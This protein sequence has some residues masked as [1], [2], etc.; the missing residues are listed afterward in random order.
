MT[1][2]HDLLIFE[3]SYR[4]LAARIHAIDPEIRISLMD[5]SGQISAAGRAIEP[6]HASA[7]IGWPN[8]DVFVS[9]R[10]SDYLRALLKSNTLRW[11]QS[12]AAGVDDPI[13]ARLAAKGL[14]LT[15]SDA[16]APAMADF[17]LGA[18]LEFH[19]EQAQRRQLQAARAWQ[20]VT[21]TELA[22]TSWL[23]VGYGHIGRE[24]ARRAHAFGAAIT[25]V[26]RD[27]QP[28]SFARSI[29]TLDHLP[30]CL[31]HADVVV[32][33]CALNHVT[34]NLADAK[35]FSAM[36]PGS[37]LINVG[38][39]ALLDE[40]ALLAA[41]QLDRPRHAVLDV[42]HTEPLPHDHPLWQHPQVKVSAHTSAFG[43]GNARRGDEL[44]LDNLARYVR[45]EPLRNVVKAE[46]CGAH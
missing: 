13:F 30:A 21:F 41:L 4:R 34:R 31:P 19:Q 45:G 16:Q 6:G 43:S 11:V 20:R 22:D 28:D 5:G 39:G 17:V 14:I 3:D 15:N 23:I 8:S 35:F 46:D 36:K 38:R 25:G 12:A 44:F 42:F 29:T 32:L 9:E 1:S 2:L 27:A 10:R 7:T 26:R 37:L 18:V 40:S 33:C 24:I